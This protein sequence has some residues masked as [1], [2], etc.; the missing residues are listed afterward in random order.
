[1]FISKGANNAH[2]NNY[3]SASIY[4]YMENQWERNIC[5]EA[6]RLAGAACVAG[7]SC[8]ALVTNSTAMPSKIYLIAM[9]EDRIL[10]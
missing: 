2:H 7:G 5:R 8:P 6:Y 4:E 3:N 10:E 1:M 9:S